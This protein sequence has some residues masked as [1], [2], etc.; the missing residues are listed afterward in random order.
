MLSDPMEY[1]GGGTYFH[2][3][4]TTLKLRQGQVLCHPGTLYHAG[5]DITAGSRLLMVSFLFGFNSE[6]EDSH[7]GDV[8]ERE[9]HR[10]TLHC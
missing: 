7:P 8:D 6:I 9:F 3:L 1:K 10:N 5:V 2:R 4:G